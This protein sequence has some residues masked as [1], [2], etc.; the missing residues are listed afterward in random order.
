MDDFLRPENLQRLNNLE[1]IA[2]FVVEGFITGRHKSPYHGFSVEFAEHRQYMP[3]DSIRHVDW[4]VYGKT[5]RFYIKQYEE[6]TNLKAYLLL[7]TSG[8]MWFK[9]G[10]VSKFTYGSYLAAALAY[11]GLKQ[12]DATGLMLFDHEV[13]D[14]LPPKAV[15]SWFHRILEKIENVR[16]GN[17]ATSLA[18]NL[19]RLAESIPRRGLVVLISDL[20]DHDEELLN[21]LKHFRHRKHEVI[22]F[23]VLDPQEETFDYRRETRFRDLET[24]EILPTHP[25]HIR[26][27]V[28]RAVADFR[29]YFRSNCRNHH[30]DY[31]Q[32]NTATPFDRALYEYLLKRR[33][34]M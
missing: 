11:L 20:L 24:G 16:P 13:R 28:Q 25:L 4:K 32:I 1:L 17:A 7:D 6:E 8:S 21:A 12:Q 2:R 26:E 15:W 19:H 34:L 22:V 29:A 33:R 27:D 23:H 31:V 30:I 14:Y 10:A 3:G 5:Q 9:S 18:A